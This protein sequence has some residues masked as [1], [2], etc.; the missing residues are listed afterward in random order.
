MIA[1][2]DN[3]DHL[4]CLL[5]DYTDSNLHTFLQGTAAFFKCSVVQ[6]SEYAQ[7]FKVGNKVSFVRNDV[8]YHF[9][10][11]ATT[12]NEELVSIQADSLTL[13]LRNEDSRAYKAS[14]AMTFKEYLDVFLFAGDN[15]I[16]LGVNEVADKKL[17]LEWEGSEDSVLARLF[18]LANKFGAEIEFETILNRHWGLD[19][20]KLNVYREHD[21][22]HQGIGKRRTDI[23][24]EY[25]H[26]IETI[27]I[28]E[29]IDNLKTAIHATGKDGLTPASVLIDE[30]DADGNRLY[31]SPIGDGSIRAVQARNQ[32]MSKVNGEG[33]IAKN[34]TYETDNPNVLAAQ[35]LAELKKISKVE[36]TVKIKGY[37]YLGIGDTII[38][39]DTGYNPVLNLEA[40]ISEQDIYFDNPENNTSTFTN[41]EILKSEVDESLLTRVRELIEENKVYDVQIL[42]S[43][44]YSFKNGQGKTTLIARVVDGPKEI[45]G[46][47]DLAWY[48]GNELQATTISLDVNA[49]AINEKVVYKLI[50]Y[51]NG[52]ERGRNEITLINVNDGKNGQ[53]GPKGDTGSAG[54]K[55]DKGEK[56]E[57]GERGPQGLQGLQGPKGDQGIAGTN[58]IDGRTS[59]THI[60]YADS[61]DGSVNFSVSDSNR[62]YIGVYVDFNQTDSTNPSSYQWSLIKGADGQDG[63]NGLP[64]KPGADGRTPYFHI[65]YADSVDGSIGFSTT[66]SVNKSYMGTYTDFTQADST[67]YKSYRWVKIQGPTGPRGANGS[68]GQ[69]LYTW[70]K[71][72][73]SPT[74]GM[75]DNP[76]GKKYLG[77][78]YGKSSSNESSN[79]SDY[80]WS[81]IQGAQGIQGPKGDKGAT[82]STGAVG[83]RGAQGI[84]GPPGQ[85]GQPTYTWIK[86]ADNASGSG[87]TDNPNGKQY[88]GIAYNK[89]TATMS[90]NPADYRWSKFIGPQGIQG[91]Q[92]ARGATGPTGPKGATG[93]QGPQGAKGDAGPRG[94]TGPQGS[95]GPKGTDGR[96]PVIHTAW[97]DST[98]GANFTLTYPSNRI[99]IYKG[100]YTDYS[101]TN[102]TNP[103]GYKWEYNPDFINSDLGKAKVS[104]TNLQNSYA[105]KT[106]TSYGKILSELNLNPNGTYIK[107]GIIKLDGNTYIDNA[108]INNLV[109]NSI[110]TNKIKSTEISGNVIKG[111]TIDGTII[112][113]TGPNG[114]TKL[115]DG[116]FISTQNNA[117]GHYGAQSVDMTI[118]DS[119]KYAGSTKL[120]YNGFINEMKNKDGVFAKR[121]ITFHSEG[122]KIEPED[123]NVGTNL[124]SGMHLVGRKAYLDFVANTTSRDDATPYHLRIIANED[125][126]SV[127]ES[128][129]GRLEIYTKNQEQ[130]VV[131]ANYIPQTTMNNDSAIKQ[132]T[133][134]NPNASG[135]YIE[136]RS[137]AGKAWGISMWL[138]DQRLK[139]NIKPS[140]LDSLDKINQLALRQFD[141][142]SDGKHEEFGLIAQEV[143]KI[144]PDAV[145]KV[146]DYYQI[147]ES[148][149]IPVL[150]GAVQKLSSKVNLLENILMNTKFKEMLV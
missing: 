143:E 6:N 127:I 117:V 80:A 69:T 129:Q 67:N 30:K 144:L 108:F 65:A 75:S 99:P 12:K 5:D 51:R 95:T 66:S 28:E 33:Y 3:Q 1:I 139:N 27:E 56:G 101:S 41:V 92:G 111:G 35:A 116:W 9:D 26:N 105:I 100:T 135:S 126:K 36:V 74:S 58:G 94:A 4:L 118:Y 31:Y 149:L 82:G 44:G 96:T 91:P 38:A 64:G 39:Q 79:Y 54:P 63:A 7:Y 124:N 72:A 87:L 148:G 19:K 70:L 13:E 140:I 133:I 142:K 130:L 81:L 150:I 62:K 52:V 123:T 47:F 17:Q 32:F 18:S 25:G 132:M 34:W 131:N 68:N 128:K 114:T 77:I 121:K 84:Q 85:N 2:L 40:R 14:K 115:T 122:F 113:S 24:L 120:T 145:F 141:W 76:S 37:E 138:S 125:G 61:A 98:S 73:D 134:A 88:L 146:G 71:Y 136:V 42:T 21:D 109:A 110:V 107:G 147:K 93:P 50:A 53:Q 48:I 102:S 22:K 104:I 119:G 23:L 90:N 46:D 97:A 10:I 112:K 20:I 43:N 103:S 49:A 11:T 78:A 57:P 86:Y 8:S 106:V 83:P 89:S 60:A 45:T 29:N 55:G 16:V 137:R 59:Y 15:P